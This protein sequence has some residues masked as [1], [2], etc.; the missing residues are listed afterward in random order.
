MGISFTTL[1]IA[2][3]VSLWA[4]SAF[5]AENILDTAHVRNHWV[6]SFTEDSIALSAAIALAFTYSVI[7]VSHKVVFDPSRRFIV[8][9]FPEYIALTKDSTQK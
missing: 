9:T 7:K 2:I 6:F 3:L 8:D 4:S 5:G 1:F